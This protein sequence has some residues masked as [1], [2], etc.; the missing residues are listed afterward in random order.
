MYVRTGFWTS[1]RAS[2]SEIIY[3]LMPWGQG[4]DYVPF[5]VTFTL[6]D[7][8]RNIWVGDRWYRHGSYTV[9]ITN[10]VTGVSYV[11]GYSGILASGSCRSTTYTDH[12][13]ATVRIYPSCVDREELLGVLNDA[14]KSYGYVDLCK[15]SDG[16]L[17]LYSSTFGPRL[18]FTSDQPVI[19]I[20]RNP[21]GTYRIV[22]SDPT[23]GKTYIYD[24]VK[25]R[26]PIK[27]YNVSRSYTYT[28]IT[29]RVTKTTS[30]S[31]VYTIYP[32]QAPALAYV[33][34]NPWDG[35]KY[36]S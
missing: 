19:S 3:L 8:G 4:A 12:W 24:D 33:D 1:Y 26:D 20:N 6:D 32:F 7:E 15:G 35:P 10:L 14:Q 30:G 22:Y 2:Q 27:W 21:D 18:N 23:A 13:T 5:K 29:A 17:Y 16:N 31:Y 11:Q 25:P 34:H 36:M 28:F 9:N